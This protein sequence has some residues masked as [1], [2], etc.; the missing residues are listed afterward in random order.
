M[1]TSTIQV[2]LTVTNAVQATADAIRDAAVA[3]YC[4]AHGLDIYV[5]P[6]TPA[7]GVDTAKAVAAFRVQVRQHIIKVIQNY[8]KDAAG[9]AAAS[10][11]EAQTA[12]DLA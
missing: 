12:T 8:R 5:M 2:P 7:S 9:V 3:D 1:A 4:K 10:A 6:N 11:A